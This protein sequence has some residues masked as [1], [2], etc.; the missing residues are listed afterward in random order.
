LPEEYAGEVPVEATAEGT[1][2]ADA[3]AE[4]TEPATAEEDAEGLL[5]WIWQRRRIR[6]RRK[7][8]C[9][10]RSLPWKGITKRSRKRDL[11][12]TGPKPTVP[13]RDFW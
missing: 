9:R 6:R 2:E 12:T 8:V 11:K 5:L 4:T 10:P 7:M 1:A 3:L 13:K